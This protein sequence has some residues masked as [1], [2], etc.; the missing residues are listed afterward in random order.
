M[1][2]VRRIFAAGLISLACNA[3]AQSYSP[4]ARSL[5]DD[6]SVEGLMKLAEIADEDEESGL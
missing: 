5:R 2:S 1:I 3:D 6:L 4:L